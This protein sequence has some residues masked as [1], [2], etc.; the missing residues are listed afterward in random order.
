MT[1]LDLGP[2]E[3]T[4]VLAITALVAGIGHLPEWRAEARPRKK[5]PKR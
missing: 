3:W 1:F 2:L 4:L 5:R